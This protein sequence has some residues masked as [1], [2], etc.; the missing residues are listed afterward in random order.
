MA[1]AVSSSFSWTAVGELFP[2]VKG[3]FLGSLIIVLAAISVANQQSTVLL[4]LSSNNSGMDTLRSSLGRLH[5]QCWEP[6]K[7]Q[8]WIWQAPSLLLIVSLFIFGLGLNLQ[9]WISYA[10]YRKDIAVR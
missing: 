6:R 8:V 3:L 10:K 1:G 4:R 5:G 9:I 2:V 7:L